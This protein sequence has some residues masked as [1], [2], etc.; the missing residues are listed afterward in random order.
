LSLDGGAWPEFDCGGQN[1]SG[2]STARA[3]EICEEGRRRWLTESAEERRR[4]REGVRAR[5]VAEGGG[6][7]GARTER[8]GQR[9]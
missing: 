2:S 6:D 3:F 9:Q 7:S 5:M 8:L 4:A 1:P